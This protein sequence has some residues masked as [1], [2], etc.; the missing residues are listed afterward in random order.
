[1]SG[2]EEDEVGTQP[3]QTLETGSMAE[4]V[5]VDVDF[6][7]KEIRAIRDG[8]HQED[9]EKGMTP[10]NAGKLREAMGLGPLDTDVLKEELEE[11]FLRP[12]A[13]VSDSLLGFAQV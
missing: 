4:E 12:R 11:R 2:E 6:F 8:R 7:E 3:L 1:M 13:R 10:V 5:E 9:E